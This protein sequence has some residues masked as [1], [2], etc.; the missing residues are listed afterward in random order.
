ML[1]ED[2]YLSEMKKNGLE[3]STIDRYQGRDKH[4]IIISFVRSNEGGNAGRLLQD[5]R[6]INVAVSRAK[7]KLI[8]IGSVG[9]LKKGSQVLSSMLELVRRRG[10]IEGLPLNAHQ[11]Y[12]II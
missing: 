1:D 7:R 5:R 3:V 12:D 11:V 9:T 10:W 6:R 8:M 2:I 4:A